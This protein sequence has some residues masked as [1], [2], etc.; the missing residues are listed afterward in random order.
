MTYETIIGL[1]VH[2]Q[3]LTESKIF[4]A[5]I[6]RFGAAPNSQTD[7]VVLGLPGVLPVLNRRAVE[8]AV[9]M[10]LAT[11]CTIAQVSRFARKHYFYPDLPK[12]YQ[13]SQYELPLCSGG[14][15][16]IEP[17]AQQKKRV[18]INRIHLEEDAGKSIHDEALA[19]D[20][21]LVDLNR[22]GVPLIEIVSE[23]DLHAPAE[24]YAYLREL[25]R[26]LVYLKICDG[27][28]EEGSLRCD[29]NISLRPAGAKE[30]GVK[31]ELKNMNSFRNV[32][33]ALTFEIERQQKILAAGGHVI[34]ETLL[35]DADAGE[36]R[37]MRGKEEAHDY[38]YFPDPDLLPLEI[39]PEYLD[40]IRRSLPELPAARR[41]RFIK[42]FGLS[43]NDADLLIDSPELADYY[44]RLAGSSKDIRL[45]GNWVL[46]DVLRVLNEKKADITE[47]PIRAEGL[48]E[49][50]NLVSEQTISLKIARTVFEEML[51][52]GDAAAK[53]VERR[54]LAQIS[55]RAAIESQVAQVMAENPEQVE[56]LKSGKEKV[57]AY[58]VGQVMKATRG[59][60][61]PGLVNEILQQKIKGG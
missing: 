35:W 57:L 34:Q 46:V 43:E 29:A 16:D 36:A 55:D 52:S 3:L 7:P 9:R 28:M 12:G 44:E 49:L 38:R 41:Q 60:A 13:I 21:T 61:N 47:F 26:L 19:G 59:K 31:T 39:T 27:N 8:F 17:A 54:G 50:L 45:A 15:L 30:L 33:R 37:P 24:A 10:G 48:A 58:L 18:R 22:S 20:Q 53:I 32:E 56:Q 5:S 1:E 11:H 25:K 51:S 14:Y 23:P 4:S 6:T 2:A 42:E 40:E